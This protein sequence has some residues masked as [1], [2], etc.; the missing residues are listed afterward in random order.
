MEQPSTEHLDQRI[1]RLERSS[2]RDRFIGLGVML[3]L[4]AT[5]QAPAPSTNTPLVVRDATGASATLTSAGLVVRDP[6][7]RTRVFAGLDGDGKPSFDLRDATGQLRQTLYLFDGSPQ[8]RQF[9]A[10]G[11][12]RTELALDPR[13]NGEL[14]LSDANEKTRLALFQRTTGPG[15]PQMQLYG[16]DGKD[17]ATF[18]TDDDSPYLILK[19]AAGGTRVYMGGY[20]DGKIGIDVRNASNGTLWSAP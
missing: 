3:V 19:D 7:G 14:L 5:A 1:G 17:R 13:G 18:S 2:R 12:R 11:K 16:S 15:D 20:R 10:A 8:V 6:A 9:D 4:I